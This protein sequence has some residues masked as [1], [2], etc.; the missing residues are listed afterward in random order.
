[1]YYIYVLKSLKYNKSYVG[2]TNN[3]HRRLSEHNLGKSTFTNKYKPWKIIYTE[4][5]ILLEEAKSREKYLKS[6]SGR[7]IVLK[8]L[9]EQ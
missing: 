4:E 9:F 8:K 5:Y 3:L 1:M 6:S 7:R 2:Y